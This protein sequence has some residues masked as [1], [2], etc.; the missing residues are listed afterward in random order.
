MPFGQLHFELLPYSI[1]STA[2][3]PHPDKN[4]DGRFSCYSFTRRFFHMFALKCNVFLPTFW[5]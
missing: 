1:F 3:F 4:Q 2:D 5:K